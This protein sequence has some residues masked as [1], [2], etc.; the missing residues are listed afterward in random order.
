VGHH[1]RLKKVE[2][3]PLRRWQMA[4]PEEQRRM[5]REMIATVN[6]KHVDAPTVYRA[7]AAKGITHKDL[8]K[9]FM[10]SRGF[11]QALVGHHGP[12][13]KMT[14]AWAERLLRY[15]AGLPYAPT[16]QQMAAAQRK[17]WQSRQARLRKE[18]T[19]KRPSLYAA[20]SEKELE[21][22]QHLTK[23]KSEWF[24]P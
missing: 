6:A 14:R 11:A 17:E 21:L 1:W 23:P 3:Q 4:H 5:G 19:A 12:C 22:T 20:V 7:L 2:Q 16:R 24:K 18:G 13:K 15:A 10:I 9:T 8:V